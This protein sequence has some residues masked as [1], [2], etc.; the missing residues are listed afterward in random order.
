VQGASAPDDLLKDYLGVLNINVGCGHNPM[1]DFINIDSDV[2]ELG[3][4]PAPF[5][6]NVAD[7]VFASH[8]LEHVVD[9]IGAM[10][11]IHRI[12]KPGGYL[13]AF[14][15]YASSDDAWEDPTHVR[16]FTENSWIYFD[17]RTYER[18]NQHGHYASDVD[19]IFDIHRIFLVP[20]P[21]FN[22]TD[23]P[24]LA[25]ARKH[26]R[27]VFREMQAILKAVK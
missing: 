14:T 7:L 11:E 13:I 6:D 18:P 15:P 23:K 8:V 17:R 10:R 26:W 16:A 27:N 22:N 4:T 24:A 21:E 1:D 3:I 9:I 2:W 12:L 5:E 25:F 20:Y 19:Y